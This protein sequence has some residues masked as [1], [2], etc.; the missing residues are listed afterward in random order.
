[1]VFRRPSVRYS[2]T[3][4]PQTPFQK[5]A[6]VWDARIGSARVQAKNWRLMAFGCLFVAGGDDDGDGGLLVSCFHHCHCGILRAQK[7]LR[8]LRGRSPGSIGRPTARVNSCPSQSL[9]HGSRI[10]GLRCW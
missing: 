6:Q 5:A 4:R 3:P 7:R 10:G 8:N 9:R 2:R 1:M